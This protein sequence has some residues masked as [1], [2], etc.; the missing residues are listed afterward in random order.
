MWNKEGRGIHRSPSD[1]PRCTT[2]HLD[3]RFR[4]LALR[5]LFATTR[6]IGYQCLEEEGRSVIMRTLYRRIRAFGRDR[7]IE[8]LYLKKKIMVVVTKKTPQTHLKLHIKIN[9]KIPDHVL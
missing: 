2:E 6:E 8:T 3:R 7:T 4:Q 5:D 1:Q 9:P